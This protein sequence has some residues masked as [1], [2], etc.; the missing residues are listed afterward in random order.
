FGKVLDG[1]LKLLVL[2]GGVSPALIDGGQFIR[3]FML[4]IGGFAEQFDGLI[5]ILVLGSI[6]ACSG[7]PVCVLGLFVGFCRIHLRRAKRESRNESKN[8]NLFHGFILDVDLL[9]QFETEVRNSWLQGQLFQ[10]CSGEGA[11]S[12]SI[13]GSGSG[14]ADELGPGSS[15][16]LM[17]TARPLVSSMSMSAPRK[18]TSPPATGNDAGRF[19]M[20]RF[21]IGSM[22]RPRMEFTGPHIPASHKKAVPLGKICSSAV[23]TWVCVPITAETLP[24]RKRPI[25]IF[26]LVVS[27]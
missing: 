19:E 9:R 6:R 7:K 14:V 22:A 21:M 27:P 24:S 25:A 13:F 11:C 12:M 1:L 23:W 3:V 18:R 5:P 8:K 17:R 4:Q 2:R 15:T 16:R 10:V 20:N 26:S